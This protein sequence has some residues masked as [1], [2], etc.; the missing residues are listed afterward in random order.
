MNTKGHHSKGHHPTSR[1]ALLGVAA[2]SAAL[3]V[4]GVAAT[5]PAWA[6][7]GPS[8]GPTQAVAASAL[9]TIAAVTSDPIT[10]AKARVDRSVDRQVATIDRVNARLANGTNLTA[11]ERTTLTTDLSER[12]T[13]LTALKA[14]VDGDSTVAAIKADVKAAAAA[15][16]GNPAVELASLHLRAADASAYVAALDRRVATMQSKLDAAKTAGKDVTA[17]QNALTDL[18]AKL[19]DAR[20]HLDGFDAAL[21]AGQPT[22]AGFAP[23]AMALKA[24]HADVTSIRKDATV[25]R[26]ALH[27]AST[28]P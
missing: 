16:K 7:S 5:S 9:P 14:K 20:S 21:P 23:A 11:S 17:A 28:R 8:A 6:G 26:Q 24:V 19:T 22:N 27:P 1:R 4:A 12:R 10:I 13:G 3:A 18:Q 2:V 25:I 15:A